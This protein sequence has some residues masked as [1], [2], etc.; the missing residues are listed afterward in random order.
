MRV[1]RALLL[2]L[3]YFRTDTMV[4]RETIADRYSFCREVSMV[5]MENLYMEEGH[6]GKPGTERGRI[7]EGLWILGKYYIVFSVNIYTRVYIE[8]QVH[9]GNKKLCI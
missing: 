6:I 2:V 3:V 8:T 5:A 7:V 9:L 1:A 4:S